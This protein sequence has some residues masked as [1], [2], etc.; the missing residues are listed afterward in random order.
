MSART[1]L[2]TGRKIVAIG[3]NFSEHAKELGNAVPQSPFFFLKPTSSYLENGGAIEIP[4]GC[5]VHH[6]I[7]LAVI[8]G[9]NG[10]DIPAVQ[11][12]EYVGGECPPTVLK[13]CLTKNSYFSGYALSIDLTA[14]DMQV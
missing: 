5:E 9:K 4:R 14:R 13:S 3:R 6:E 7:E 10:R 12:D 2:T 11:A 8:I 1:F